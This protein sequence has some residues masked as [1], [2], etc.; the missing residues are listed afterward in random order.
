MLIPSRLKNPCVGLTSAYARQVEV[1]LFE[2]PAPR[3]DD[4][5]EFELTVLRLVLMS[6]KFI[7][8]CLILDHEAAWLKNLIRSSTT[9]RGVKGQCW[10]LVGWR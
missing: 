8:P 9:N 2:P 10:V 3:D 4:D 7:I 5:D 6:L 1:C